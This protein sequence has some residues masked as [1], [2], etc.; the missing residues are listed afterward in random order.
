MKPIFIVFIA[1]GRIK[2]LVDG[3]Q[4]IT[5]SKHLDKDDL[6]LSGNVVMP[7]KDKVD[8][9]INIIKTEFLQHIRINKMFANRLIFA[10]HLNAIN[11]FFQIY[12]TNCFLGGQFYNLGVDFWR[13]DFSGKMDVL[14]IVFPKVTK[15]NFYKYGASG[16]IQKH[17]ALCVMALNVINEKIFVVL[18]FWYW[19]LA[20]ITITALIWRV[21]TILMHSRYGGQFDYWIDLWFLK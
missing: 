5:L 3:L 19:L 16:S 4:M 1:G 18:W 8:G 11:L 10:E 21:F 7:S 9:R 13:D 12:C 20:I 2:A 17:D 15:C 6:R 14:D